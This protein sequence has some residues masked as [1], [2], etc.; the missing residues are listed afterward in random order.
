MP[1]DKIN[2]VKFVSSVNSFKS[3]TATNLLSSI[4]TMVL[5]NRVKN[6]QKNIPLAPYTTFKIGG[7]AKYF[8][9]AT[10]EKDLIKIIKIAREEKI[11][12]FILGNGSNI[13]ISDEGFI[14]LAI[15]NLTREA[16]IIRNLKQKI[17]FEQKL[18]A[19]FFPVH[20]DKY[21]R[22]SDLN[23]QTEPFDVEV[24]V[25][26]GMPLQSFIQWA[27]K[28]KLTGLQWFAGIP[29]SI[30]G[31]IVYN[32]HG[33]A[34]LFS[35]Y[36][37]EIVVLDKNNRLKKIKKNNIKF[38]YDFSSIKKEKLVILR[39]KIFL[40]HGDIKR[41]QF[42]YQEWFKRKLKIQAQTN[43]SGSI[44]KNISLKTA[45]K[46]NVPTVSAGYLIDQCGLKGKKIGKAI[47][48][49]KHANFIINTGQATAK[50]VIML[51][52]L[53][54]EKVRNKFN[55]QLQEEIQYIGF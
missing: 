50:N 10:T 34:K 42:I 54:K 35:D 13:L 48:S 11:P 8:Y 30:G 16:K 4:S 39:A 12:F 38:D 43:C 3:S 33:G 22:F 52:S 46:I 36:I 31:A 19:R 18:D 15:K 5:F 40:S 27:F 37:S 41:A 53:I 32:I 49:E 1:F 44:F 6:I 24:E 28:N 23:Y 55:V 2:P 21:L 20:S 47:V 25:S 45:K 14:G 9:L 51:I 17:N 26:S 7:P 29:G